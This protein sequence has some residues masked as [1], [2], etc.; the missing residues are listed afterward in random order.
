MTVTPSYGYNAKVN[1][2][3][4]IAIF[5]PEFGYYS[6]PEANS[7]RGTPSNGLVNN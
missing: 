5:R 7:S 1:D 4:K 2:P 3:C 6:T